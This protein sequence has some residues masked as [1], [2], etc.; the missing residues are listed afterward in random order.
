MSSL[1]VVLIPALSCAGAPQNG[2]PVVSA[3]R[4][5][6]SDDAARPALGLDWT[7]RRRYAQLVTWSATRTIAFVQLES[8]SDARQARTAAEPRLSSACVE[9]RGSSRVDVPVKQNFRQARDRL[10]L[11]AASSQGR[12]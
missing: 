9:P 7:L 3:L 5:W 12:R 10:A 2:L 4:D 11:R 8:L 1:A 6:P